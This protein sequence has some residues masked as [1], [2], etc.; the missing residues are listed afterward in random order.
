MVGDL[1]M[2]AETHKAFLMRLARNPEGSISEKSQSEYLA[3]KVTEDLVKLL[4]TMGYMPQKPKEVIGDFTHHMSGLN[5][6][7]SFDELKGVLDEVVRVAEETGTITPELKS[8]V[9]ALNS[10]LEKAEIE[11]EAKRLLNEPKQENKED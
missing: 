7:K 9:N 1:L 3:W 8:N 5:S 6:E 4:Q 10:R 2:K 11:Y